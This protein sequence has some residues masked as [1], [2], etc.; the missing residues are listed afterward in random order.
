VCSD[1]EGVVVLERCVLQ[2]LRYGILCSEQSR[3]WANR[4]VLRDNC[5]GLSLSHTAQLTLRAS[6]VLAHS[7]GV[8]QVVAEHPGALNSLPASTLHLIDNVAYLGTENDKLFRCPQLMPRYIIDRN[9]RLVYHAAPAHLTLPHPEPPELYA[10]D[11]TP[12]DI[13]EFA[14]EV[15]AVTGQPG[16]SKT[17]PGSWRVEWIA[18]SKFR[19]LQGDQEG[20]ERVTRQYYQPDYQPEVQEEEAQEEEE[21]GAQ[22]SYAWYINDEEG[23]MQLTHPLVEMREK[24]SEERE[25]QRY[26]RALCRNTTE[27]DKRKV[28]EESDDESVIEEEEEEA[29]V[30]EALD[31]SSEGGGGKEE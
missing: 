22:Q 2:Q 17:L 30:E 29:E 12:I 21:E 8:I 16:T 5:I 24:I 6:S 31:V 14:F 23:R 10:V 1:G 3:V 4:C 11:G 18:T 20:P 26:L 19:G 9:N 7:E 28:K 15:D 27:S 13:N 25:C